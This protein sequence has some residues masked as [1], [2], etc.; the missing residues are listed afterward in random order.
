VKKAVQL[1]D[2]VTDAAMCIAS[3]AQPHT[4][5]LELDIGGGREYVFPQ[6]SISYPKL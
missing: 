4:V 2:S 1:A 6:D 3:V 5:D